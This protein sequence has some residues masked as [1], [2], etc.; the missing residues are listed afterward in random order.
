[1]QDGFQSPKTQPKRAK[2][3]K[4]GQKQKK[5]PQNPKKFVEIAVFPL[6]LPT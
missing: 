4:N 5:T 1:V 6:T 2:P 3:G